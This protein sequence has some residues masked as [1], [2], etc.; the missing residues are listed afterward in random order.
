MVESHSKVAVITPV[1]N[2]ITHIKTA[3]LSV[4]YQTH[5][6]CAHYIYDDGSNDGTKEYLKSLA[7][8]LNINIILSDINNGQSNGRNKAIEQALAD[9]CDFIAFLDS[10]DWWDKFHIEKSLLAIGNN[11]VVYSRPHLTLEGGV[12]TKPLNIP[13]PAIFIAKQLL[14]G[15]YIWISS[16]VARSTCFQTAR[17]DDSLNSIEDWDMWIQLSKDGYKFVRSAQSTS[18]YLVRNNGQGSK[19]TEK[20]KLLENKHA[21]LTS[22]KLNLACGD[23]YLND[24]INVDLYPVSGQRVDAKF[25]VRSLPY[26]DDSIDEIRA[27]HIIEHFDW[28]EGNRVLAEWARVLKPG[29]KLWIETPD[30]LASCR[31]FVEGDLETRTNLLGHF[32]ATP[33]IEGQTHKFLFEENQLQTQLSWAGFERFAR[34]PPSS[35]Y[36]RFDFYKNRPEIFLC[37]EAFKTYNKTRSN[38]DLDKLEKYDPATYKEIFVDNIYGVEIDDIKGRTVIDLGANLGMFSLLSWQYGAKKIVSVEAQPYI[39]NNGLSVI[40]QYHEDIVRLNL[41]ASDKDNQTVLIANNHVCSQI[42]NNEGDPVQTITI[43]TLLETNKIFEYDLVLKIDIEGSEFPA[44]L[45]CDIDTLRRFA[46]IFCELHTNY[47][48]NPEWQEPDSIRTLLQSAGFICVKSSKTV[49][50]GHDLYTEKWTQINSFQ[51]N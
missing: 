22:C 15:N 2:D 50:Y 16:V 51:L 31:A 5:T 23:D 46:I 14:Y 38:L 20:R 45:G 21:L 42:S 41:A 27:F 33:W 11:D 1:Y 39:F 3:I 19:G 12:V 48:D 10:D 40:T 17:F 34:L 25:D 47:H 13:E 18:T 8:D 30:F 28:Q 26:P 29:G 35:S 32:F 4:T 36:L 9:G 44:L 24:Y 6:N 49:F 37:A 43:P 7:D